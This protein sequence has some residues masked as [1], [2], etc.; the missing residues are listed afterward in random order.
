V[1]PGSTIISEVKASQCLYDDIAKQGGR[2]I[3]W[4]TGH[5]LIKA[6]MKSEEAVL[7]GEMS[8]HMFFA[9]RYFGYDVFQYIVPDP[10]VVYAVML[11]SGILLFI[12]RCRRS[13]LSLEHATGMALWAALAALAGARIFYLV[14]HLGFTL[15]HPSV[16]LEINGATVSSASTWEAFWARFCTP[17][18]STSSRF[19]STSTSS[20]PSS[21]WDQ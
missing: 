5:S 15:A 3:M 21:V 14:Q 6:K 4:K 19:P 2:P 12:R 9:D 20:R 17:A 11:G 16:L 7:A 13:G 8:G 10:A 18:R 1:K